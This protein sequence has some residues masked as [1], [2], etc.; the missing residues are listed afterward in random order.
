MADRSSPIPTISIVVEGDADE[1]VAR[2]LV[3]HVG[4][5]SGTVYGR[6]GKAK[7]L[8]SVH[9]Y[10]NAA[11]RSPWFVLIDLDRDAECAPTLRAA[12]LPRVSKWLCFR[13]AVREIESWLLAD[14][15]S[16]ARFLGVRERAIPRDPDNDPD[17]KATVVNL[18]RQSSHRGIRE[19][20]VPT[21]RSGRRVG[22]A[23]TSRMIEFARQHWD[24]ERATASSPSLES[25]VA[26]LA[27]LVKRY[28]AEGHLS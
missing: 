23:Y 19:D 2:R 7:V 15:Q 18:A 28:A 1:A 27:D 22:I 12:C 26:C 11:Q 13:I 6:S 8:S 5:M 21:E 4:G 25:A 20:L 14:R 3:E 17:P 24:I 16:L 10:T 9:G